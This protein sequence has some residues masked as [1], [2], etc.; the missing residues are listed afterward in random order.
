MRNIITTIFMAIAMILTFSS[1][2][3]FLDTKS[4]SSF[5]EETI[6]SDPV[7]AEG[8]LLGAYATLGENNSYRNRLIHTGY[9]SDVEMHNNSLSGLT[10]NNRRALAIYRIAANNG[11]MDATNGNE[12]YSMPFSAIERL[13]VVLKGIKTYNDISIP[14]VGHVYGEALCLRA[15]FY[16]DLIKWYGDIPARF[17]PVTSAT[18]YLHKSDRDVIYKQILADLKE[19]AD[20][21]PWPNETTKYSRVDRMNKM[22]AKALRARVA[23]FAGG[24][25]LRPDVNDMRLSNDPEL[26][27]NAMYTIARQECLDIME[28][29]TGKV[30]LA[31]NFEDIFR[32]NLNEVISCGRESIFEFPYNP[33]VRGQWLS[34]FGG[35][36]DGKDKYTNAQVKGEA[37]PTPAM[38][39]NYDD[40]D[41][42]RDVS[43]VPYK[44]VVND[45]ET[46]QVIQ[47]S[48]STP[49][50][51]RWYFGKLR[52]EWCKTPMSGNDDGIKPINMRYA[53]VILMFAEAEN[54]LNGPTTEAKDALKNIRNRAFAVA[55]R[56]EKVESY[57]DA[58]S[59]KGAFFNAIVDERAFEFCGEMM[60]KYDLTRWNLLKTKLDEARENIRK[61]RDG[62][63]KYADY[64]RYIFWRRNPA[65]NELVDIYG[66]KKGEFPRN[67]AGNIIVNPADKS[68]DIV[69]A[70]TAWFQSF[71]GATA[72]K[73]WGPYTGTGNAIVEWLDSRND[74]DSRI[75]SDQY[76][77]NAF[78][79]EGVNPNLR[80]LFPIWA[81]PL[82]KS[83]GYLTNDYGY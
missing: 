20:L 48:S 33:Q 52:A 63:A 69:A 12:L 29:S 11:D 41:L 45:G 55:D 73:P 66:L 56:T 51:R 24:Y 4:Q 17:E 53:D 31:I 14:A 49:N 59:T 71:D 61:L 79:M 60:R 35:L 39:Y 28:N 8:A 18:I 34:F 30:M 74:Q 22:Y 5:D 78:Y 42:R 32:D 50:A 70:M 81:N 27:R 65:N 80:S 15:F 6:F 58:L 47:S 44:Y 64:P 67:S 7:L 38:W 3:D 13:N 40:K 57:V 2:Q 1:C 76:I 36:H 21:L 72:E 9:N 46:Q 82:T 75:F 77:N 83:Q 62:D 43:I 10:E 19:A 26:S 37:G 54:E 23:L 25:A 16:F 68:P